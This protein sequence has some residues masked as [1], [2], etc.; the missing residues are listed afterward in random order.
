MNIA[1]SKVFPSAIPGCWSTVREP[2]ILPSSCILSHPPKVSMSSGSTL[3]CIIIAMHFAKLT[4]FEPDMPSSCISSRAHTSS[5][6]PKVSLLLRGSALQRGIIAMHFAK[7]VYFEPDLPIR[8]IFTNTVHLW[9]IW[10]PVLRRFPGRGS[11]GS[12]EVGRHGY[13][14]YVGV[15]GM[16]TCPT[17]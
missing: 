8:R 13:L 3:Q 15:C 7:L 5:H 4:Y 17:K 12:W 10:K 2:C 11:P 1:G 14:P 9:Q 16:E 6:P